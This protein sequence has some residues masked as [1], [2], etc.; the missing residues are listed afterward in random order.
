MSV[1]GFE[2]FFDGDNELP[3]NYNPVIEA[4][5]LSIS[6]M[7]SLAVEKFSLEIPPNETTAI[8]GPSGS[9]KSTLLRSFNRM[10]DTLPGVTIDGEVYYHGHNIYGPGVD[11]IEIRRR[12]GMV[13]QRPNP[14]PKSIYENVAFG[15][16][17]IHGKKAGLDDI[18]ERSLTQAALWDSVKNKLKKS[19]FGLSGGE[20]QRL[21]IAR[22]LAVEPDVILMDEPCSSLDPISTGQIEQLIKNLSLDHTI[23]LVTHN[24]YQAAR[25]AQRTAFMTV[26]LD[27]EGHR[28]GHLEEFAT[29]AEL[30][31]NPKSQR[32]EAYITGHEG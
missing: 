31:T 3:E 15:P 25:V 28:I 20:Q 30:F 12:I 2:S 32:T 11:P 29:S 4:K 7:G 21:C 18:V 17:K 23:I 6:Y 9:G 22:T 1:N 27:D 26:D 5:H 24:M 19:A 10:N 8:I 14:F 13:F 16:R